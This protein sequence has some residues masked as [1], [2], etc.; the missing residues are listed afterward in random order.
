MYER[1]TYEI[2]KEPLFGLPLCRILY[3]D[4]VIRE[5]YAPINVVQEMVTLLN[6]AYEEGH[7]R[8]LAGLE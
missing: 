8:A 6:C 7:R 1:Y 4:T 3:D 2:V 5:A